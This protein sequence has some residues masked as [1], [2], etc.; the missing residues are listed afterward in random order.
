LK[1][2]ITSQGNNANPHSFENIQKKHMDKVFAW[3]SWLISAFREFRLSYAHRQRPNVAPLAQSDASECAPFLAALKIIPE[4]DLVA[5]IRHA[6]VVGPRCEL[7]AIKA[8]GF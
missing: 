7:M 4:K 1:K 2:A 6:H 5:E 3:M 8:N